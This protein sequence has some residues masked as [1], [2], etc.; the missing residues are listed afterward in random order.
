M[1]TINPKLLA[2]ILEDLQGEMTRW[3]T[4]AG[5]TMVIADGTQRQATENFD[6]QQHRANILREEAANDV[7]TTTNE[8]LAIENLVAEL[9]E[10]RR[11]AQTTVGDANRA[12]QQAQNALRHW[13][14]ELDY[15]Q[16]WL[17]RAQERVR[18]AELELEAAKAAFE[19][20]Q[21]ELSRAV[22]A[23]QDCVNYRDSEG[24]RRDCSGARA[25]VASAE[26]AA[27]AAAVRVKEAI[28]EL[29]DAV[30][31]LQRATLR[32]ACCQK[33][34]ALSEA[35]VATAGEARE[36]AATS[37]NTAE[38]GQESAATALQYATQASRQA[39]EEEAEAEEVV[40]HVRAAGEYVAEAG[41]QLRQAERSEISA[42]RMRIMANAELT[43][44]VDRLYEMNRPN[45]A[46]APSAGVSSSVSHTSAGN[47]LHIVDGGSSRASDFVEGKMQR[48]GIADLSNPA[49]WG[50][51]SHKAIQDYILDRDPGAAVEKYVAVIDENGNQ[52]KGFID[53]LTQGVILEIKTHDLDQFSDHQLDK[54]LDRF[55]RQLEGY[56]HSPDVLGLPNM[57]IFL[58]K[59]P[60]ATGR[61]QAIESFFRGRGIAVIWGNV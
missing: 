47:V 21:R 53:A 30:A 19:A 20:A 40:T 57:A 24:R 10:A 25:R 13:R 27:H 1:G 14:G 43:D 37:L 17:K 48:T 28:A 18:L 41:H 49:E 33:A 34:V 16:A 54:T 55:A 29:E 36:A 44:R 7:E 22:S 32:V 12:W 61:G 52:R 15:A 11:A 50:K 26:A 2:V 38:R 6:Q 56:Q 8:Q 51:F 39:A 59:R 5:E 46:G 35:A 3:A 42:Q 58:E 31:E 4:T 23:L 60:H 45:L 9:Q